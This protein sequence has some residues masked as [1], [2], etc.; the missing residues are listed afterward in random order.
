MFVYG[1][2]GIHSMNIFAYSYNG[3]LSMNMFVCGNTGIQYTYMSA[4][5]NTG[6][7]SMDI[8]LCGKYRYPVYEHVCISIQVSS[9]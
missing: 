9:L 6:A 7:Q 5:V 2:I 8:F 3:I 1:N 4:Y